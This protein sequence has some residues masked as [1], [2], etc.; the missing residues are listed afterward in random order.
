MGSQKRLMQHPDALTL[1]QYIEAALSPAC[2]R[3]AIAG[4]I[5]RRK[6]KVGD[7]E[8]LTIPKIGAVQRGGTLFSEQGCLLNRALHKRVE[9]GTLEVV[10]GHGGDHKF[11]Q[12][13]I[14]PPVVTDPVGLDIFTATREG[15]GYQL[16]IRTGPADYSQRL[17]TQRYK[18]GLLDDEYRTHKGH[19]W[20]SGTA[21]AHA[22]IS[23]TTDQH[24]AG[25]MPLMIDDAPWFLHRVPEEED[26]FKLI[27][28]GY[29]EPHQRR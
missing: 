19:V 12:Y 22:G 16:A 17:V 28:G 27:K 23:G 9:A 6:E 13:R 25:L 1:A 29:V 21:M 7:I 20:R 18:G 4:S 10:K 8:L 3:I 15:W 26:F 24:Y 2:D 14:M 11:R 5:R